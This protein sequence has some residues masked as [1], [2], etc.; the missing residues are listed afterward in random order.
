MTAT[1][2]CLVRQHN[3][4]HQF[5]PDTK[6]GPVNE[7]FSM[8]APIG[9][10]S[11]TLNLFHRHVARGLWQS[12][13]VNRALEALPVSTA[14][15]I[16]DH[17]QKVEPMNYNE[18]S[19]AYYGKKGIS[20]LSFAIHYKVADNASIQVFYFDFVITSSKQDASQVQT[21]LQEFLKYV[22]LHFAFIKRVIIVSDNGTSL[23]NA[24][25]VG[26]VWRRN[27]DRWNADIIIERWLFFEA[28]CGKTILDTHFSYVGLAIRR[29]ARAVRN[30]ATPAD[31]FDA[32]THGKGIQNTSTVLLSMD[33]QRDADN[34][35][36]GVEEVDSASNFTGSRSIHGIVFADPTETA[37]LAIVRTFQYSNAAM[38]TCTFLDSQPF[39]TR[40]GRI[41]KEHFTAVPLFAPVIMDP[42]TSALAVANENVSNVSG[43]P[44][45]DRVEREYLALSGARSKVVEEIATAPGTVGPVETTI[46]PCD[47]K[48]KKKKR[49]RKR[50][51]SWYILGTSSPILANS[52]PQGI[53]VKPFRWGMT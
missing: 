19:V 20:I 33:T 46:L 36:E 53:C 15:V 14:L 11:R 31:V 8:L 49:K 2:I 7:L 16:M 17:K 3:G 39:P 5:N 42:T 4:I 30:A 18:S 12:K 32:I 50:K 6:G 9:C 37:Q 40:F 35:D 13:A 25:N 51:T 26:F 41:E 29:F 38:E 23:S 24:S 10:H 44:H 52:G 22:Q 34:A 28:Q 21:A 27:K 47:A 1:Q 48:S 43:L 45:W